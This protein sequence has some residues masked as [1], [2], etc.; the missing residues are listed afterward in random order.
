MKMVV[1]VSEPVERW[2][3]AAAGLAGQ[4]KGQLIDRIVRYHAGD[5]EIQEQI[6]LE[7]LFEV[8][9]NSLAIVFDE[10]IV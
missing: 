10:R 2:L 5:M 6:V 4:R 8:C 7:Q 3:S 9:E 1:Y